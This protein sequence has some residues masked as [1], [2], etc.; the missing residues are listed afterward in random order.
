MKIIVNR[1]ILSILLLLVVLVG[2]EDY[3][4]EPEIKR[5]TPEAYK[6]DIEFTKSEATLEEPVIN[7]EVLLFSG[8]LV[9]NRYESYEGEFGIGV[10]RVYKGDAAK[11]RLPKE[12]M[13]KELKEGTVWVIV[14]L[15]VYNF[16]TGDELLAFS[17]DEIKLYTH[18]GK[19]IKVL[20]VGKETSPESVGVYNGQIK[21]VDIVGKV[22]D[23]TEVL[24][25][26]ISKLI[27]E[28]SLDDENKE[29]GNEEENTEVITKYLSTEGVTTI[30]DFYGEIEEEN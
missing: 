6:E 15:D 13:E 23:K 18:E 12:Y 21:K 20:G 29:F 24:L 16:N 22:K 14:E 27:K 7:G 11:Y 25:V 26:G 19:E 9:K 2:C 1:K 28:Y 10:N 8:E 3:V 30:E 5:I 4:E 17:K